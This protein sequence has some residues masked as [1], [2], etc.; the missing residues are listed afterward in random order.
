MI[1]ITI[2]ISILLSA[3]Q[4]QIPFA[5]NALVWL[6]GKISIVSGDTVLLDKSGNGR[7]FK[8]SNVDFAIDNTQKGFPYKTAATIS[9]PAGNSTLIAADIDSFF[10]TSSGPN[11][12]PVVSLFQDIDYV[13]KI[14]TRHVLQVIDADSIEVR[15]PY[16]QDLVFYNTVKTGTDLNKCN[17]YFRVPTEMDSTQAVWIAPWGVDAT[18]TG[19]KARPYKTWD[20]V[21]AQTKHVY[22]ATG[23]YT[24]TANTTMSGSAINVIGTGYAKIIPTAFYIRWSKT[25]GSTISGIIDDNNISGA[26]YAA[27]FDNAVTFNRC[28]LGRSNSTA[29]AWGFGYA[30]LTDLTFNNCVFNCSTGSTYGVFRFSGSMTSFKYNGCYGATGSGYASASVCTNTTITYNKFTQFAHRFVSTTCYTLGNTVKGDFTQPQSTNYYVNKNAVTDGGIYISQSNNPVVK[31]N[32]V[33]SAVSSTTAEK[34]AFQITSLTGSWKGGE[35]MYNDFTATVGS[36]SAVLILYTDSV[37]VIGNKITNVYSGG[38][39]GGHS[40]FMNGGI[41]CTVKYNFITYTNGHGIVVKSAGRTFSDST[42]PHVSYNIF[43]STGNC[44]DVVWNRGTPGLVFANN[45]AIDFRGTS[46]IY[47]LDDDANGYFSS[48]TCFNNAIQF[49]G[50]VTAFTNGG[51]AA[52]VFRNNTI[53][54]NGN[55]VPTPPGGNTTISILIN[56]NGVPASKIEYAENPG[57]PYNVGLAQDFSIPNNLKFQNQGSTWQNGAV[58]LQ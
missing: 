5:N 32:T 17:N 54:G 14:F 39:T 15:Q 38:L 7:H 42:H 24:L 21:K 28:K 1:R 23:G 35:I 31:Y 10:Y 37:K 53:N 36:G 33:N 4:A 20:K 6:D 22:V 46:F 58:I 50:A 40:L 56:S 27:Q 3:A 25:A 12:I 29:Q 8:I 11:Q 45:T 47:G 9:A 26:S 16:V 18:G 30:T 41:D 34:P 2:F 57:A 13:H 48:M 55:T 49:G 43:K 44:F 52:I 19:S 51:G